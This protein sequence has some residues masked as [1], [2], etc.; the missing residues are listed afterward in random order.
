MIPGGLIQ[1]SGFSFTR[2]EKHLPIPPIPLTAE[3][4][5]TPVETT[6]FNCC[7]PLAVVT[8]YRDSLACWTA[9]LEQVFL[10]SLDPA[11]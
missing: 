7:P 10:L 1:Q 9:L 5:W 11:P 4:V 6:C 2:Q 3:A 8:K